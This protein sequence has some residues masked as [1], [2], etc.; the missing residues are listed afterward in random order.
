LSITRRKRHNE[1]EYGN[2]D[3]GIYRRRV[4]YL[5]HGGHGTVVQHDRF[6]VCARN[7]GVMVATLKR[8]G[9]EECERRQP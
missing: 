7:N 9:I 5:C 1:M 8:V 4:W 2:G 6:V 3:N